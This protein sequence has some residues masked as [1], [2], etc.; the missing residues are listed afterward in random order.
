MFIQGVGT[1]T[2]EFHYTQRDCWNTLAASQYLPKLSGR[3]QAIL[4][5]V[6]T[7]DSGIE[8]RSFAISN[9][10]E[11]FSLDPNTLHRRFAENAP[12][13]ASAAAERAFATAAVTAHDIDALVVSTCTGYVCPGL[14]SYISERLGLRPNAYLADLVGHLGADALDLLQ[15]L[16][17]GGDGLKVEGERRD[18]PGRPRVGAGAERVHAQEL[19]HLGHLHEHLRDGL[20][21]RHGRS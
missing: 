18:A 9:L 7:G 20:V 8:T 2:P 13:V 17:I 15:L 5:K 10:D 16:L 14:T 1:A 11:A 3:S 21:D 6:L 19:H 12:K 4:R